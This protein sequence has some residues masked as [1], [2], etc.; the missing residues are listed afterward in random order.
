MIGMRMLAG[1]A[2]DA[3]TMTEALVYF[4]T[5]EW[6]ALLEWLEFHGIDPKTIPAGTRVSRDACGR[7]IR[8][9]G[10]LLDS[11]GRRAHTGPP[12][13]QFVTMPMIEQGEAPPLPYPDLVAALLQPVEPISRS[14]VGLPV[15][16]DDQ[17]DLLG[18]T[19]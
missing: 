3:D 1:I 10:I 13:F 15:I 14:V 2:A 18:D 8:F 12:D 9:V 4:E 19:T 7:C 11:D 6:M 17:L 16:D 5:P